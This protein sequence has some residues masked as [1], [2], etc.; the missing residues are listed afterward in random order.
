MSDDE[1]VERGLRAFRRKQ[2]KLTDPADRKALEDRL[3]KGPII[4]DQKYGFQLEVYENA[5]KSWGIYN[6]FEDI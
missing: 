5:P 1:L 2:Q 3:L 6:P 4:L